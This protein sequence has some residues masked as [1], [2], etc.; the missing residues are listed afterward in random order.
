[1]KENKIEGHYQ[2]RED[3]STSL[4][5]LVELKRNGVEGLDCLIEQTIKELMDL[6]GISPEIVDRFIKKPMSEAYKRAEN[7]E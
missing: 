6:R 2:L 7:R 1:M 5:N 3:L 4:R